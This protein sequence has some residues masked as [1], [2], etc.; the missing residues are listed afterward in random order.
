MCHGI[1][2]V[3]HIL[4]VIQR[5]DVESA[6]RELDSMLLTVMLLKFRVL[7]ILSTHVEISTEG[8]IFDG[9]LKN[10]LAINT[11]A[12]SVENINPNVAIIAM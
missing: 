2:L 3:E 10:P 7:F 5:L 1:R 9:C 12:T 11:S 4:Y 6:H 8:Y